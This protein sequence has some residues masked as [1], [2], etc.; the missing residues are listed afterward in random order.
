MTR[1]EKREM[2][3]IEVMGYRQALDYAYT[4]SG[5]KNYPKYAIISIQEPTFGYGIGIE[6]KVGGNCLAALNIEFGDVTPAAVKLGD[7]DANAISAQLMTMDHARKIHDFVETLPDAVQLLIIHC[8]AG[9][10]RS[11]AVAAAISKV[12]TG[13]DSRFFKSKC[14]VPNMHVYYN[15]LE[16]YGFTNRYMDENYEKEYNAIWHN[17]EERVSINLDEV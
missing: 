9:V 7:E 8:H 6:M 3:K 15:V 17:T 12:K 13:D 14:Y 2:Y 10:S 1:W 11:A 4:Y 5:L 16:A